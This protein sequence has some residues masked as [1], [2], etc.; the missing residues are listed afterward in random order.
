MHSLS[1]TVAHSRLRYRIEYVL[2]WVMGKFIG[3]LPRPLA[4]TTGIAIGFL[5]YLFHPRLRRVG[6]RNLAMAMPEKT[7]AQRRLILRGVYKSLGRQLAEFCLFPRY[8]REN[9][10]SVVIY[11]GF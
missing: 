4:R 7:S 10:P 6:Q 8:T 1:A 3:L 5:V 9:V 11:D 2:V